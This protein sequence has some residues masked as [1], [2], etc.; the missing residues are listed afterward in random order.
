MLNTCVV[1]TKNFFWL[2]F[3]GFRVLMPYYL[4]AL[5]NIFSK[6]NVE[7]NVRVASI[8]LLSSIISFP[9]IFGQSTLALR[10]PKDLESKMDILLDS[11]GKTLPEITTYAA[12]KHYISQILLKALRSDDL[13]NMPLFGCLLLHYYEVADDD[14]DFAHQVIEALSKQ[15]TNAKDT[16]VLI[17]IF[18]TFSGFASLFNK[19][20]HNFEVILFKKQYKTFF[21]LVLM[22]RKQMPS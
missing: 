22:N 6:P 15:L 2:D 1:Q 8:E 20:P 11:K 4:Y 5:A 7:R 12:V 14:T 9:N 3:D 13:N 19:I 16:K 21:E 17:A 10:L 18:R